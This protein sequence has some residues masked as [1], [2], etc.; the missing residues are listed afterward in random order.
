MNNL[1]VLVL[2]T[3]VWEIMYINLY[4]DCLIENPTH[5]MNTIIRTTKMRGIQFYSKQYS[6]KSIKK[7]NHSIYSLTSVYYRKYCLKL[8]L[9]LTD[10]EQHTVI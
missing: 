4:R 8:P 1:L 7:S 2:Q 9:T 3:E 5:F 6:Q 10:R